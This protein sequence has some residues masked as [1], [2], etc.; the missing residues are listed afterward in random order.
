M[1]EIVFMQHEFDDLALVA[2]AERDLFHDTTRIVGAGLVISFAIFGVI[3][4]RD[5]QV[6]GFLKYH[7]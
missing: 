4:L 1:L 7:V 5:R 6:S 2:V 3:G